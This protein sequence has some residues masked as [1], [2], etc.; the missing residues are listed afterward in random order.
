LNAVPLSQGLASLSDK[1]FAGGQ[2][3]LEA[4]VVGAELAGQSNNG[5]L[6]WVHGPQPGYS[7]EIYIMSPFARKPKFFELPLDNGETDTREFLKNHEEILPVAAVPRTGSI[8]YDMQHFLDRWTSGDAETKVAFAGGARSDKHYSASSAESREVAALWANQRV[9][10]LLAQHRYTDAATIAVEHQ[11]LTP[12]SLAAVFQER[13]YSRYNFQ[14]PVP[15]TS[16]SP[17]PGSPFNSSFIQG[18]T[19]GTIG[20]Q[21][22]DATVVSGV[23]T[24]GVVRVNNLANLESLLNIFA[25]SSELLG[26]LF[27]SILLFT[28]VAGSE[29]GAT[30]LGV[31]LPFSKT[32]RMALGI[33]IILGGLAVPGFIN[34][35]VCS[36]RDANLFA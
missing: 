5:A 4:V 31:Y 1:S 32:L 15:Q 24:A 6:L 3:N 7:K 18:A 14:S 19:N 29:K 17:Q 11:V 36:A 8:K 10:E 9:Q 12:V 22:G 25:N 26:I 23:N 34:Y 2:D 20:S 21:S 16:E 28:A 13:T 35:M 33:A 27:G 30:I